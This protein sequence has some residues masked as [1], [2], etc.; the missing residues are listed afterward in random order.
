M[1]R[2]K[3]QND[4]I[5]VSGL[6]GCGKT[7]VATA[8]GFLQYLYYKRHG[9]HKKIYANY[10]LMF[11]FEPVTTLDGLYK[12]RGG[13]ALMDELWRFLSARRSMKQDNLDVLSDVVE[14]LRKNDITMFFTTHHPMHIDSMIR[15]VVT[16]YI[17][18]EIRPMYVPVK[19]EIAK[20]V[21]ERGLP[22]EEEA[23]IYI[24]VKKMLYHPKNY[25]V[26]VPIYNEYDQLI[27]A[28]FL[29]DLSYWGDLFR[30]EERI[31]KF[32]DNGG[33][34]ERHGIPLEKEF[35]NE[36]KK[37]I[38]S[39]YVYR[40]PNSGMGSPY[41]GDVICKR[42]LIDVKSLDVRNVIDVRS[43]IWDEYFANQ[44]NFG[45]KPYLAI[46][47]NKQWLVIPIEKGMEFLENTAGVSI[48]VLEKYA[49]SLKDYCKSVTS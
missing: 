16:R 19:K 18:P 36:L 6:Q 46:K 31:G 44:R 48:T 11:P 42:D 10:K 23:K 12:M 5:M 24:K 20:L 8:F 33:K 32:D 7:L 47:Y 21:A 22:K 39:E 27:N 1:D 49:M 4:I 26:Y 29:K 38:P 40:L 2:F 14:N 25:G 45:L 13:I 9:I 43:R 15:R 30:T 37:L 34:L 3:L 35:E 41:P 17:V 28:H